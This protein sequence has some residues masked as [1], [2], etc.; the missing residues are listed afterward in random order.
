MHQDL[1]RDS[2][3]EVEFVDDEAA[4]AIFMTP[5]YDVR[6]ALAKPGA[7]MYLALAL[8]QLKPRAPRVA[9]R[10]TTARRLSHAGIRRHRS[11]RKV[12]GSPHRRRSEDDPEPL[13]A[14]VAA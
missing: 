7:A 12:R 10:R 1:R 5:R 4:F 3:E 6:A 9:A 8:R 2:T 14:R 13:T 11:A